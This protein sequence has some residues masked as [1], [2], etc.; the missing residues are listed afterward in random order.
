MADLI[1]I[2]QPEPQAL[3]P[4]DARREV[5]LTVAGRVVRF[6]FTRITGKMWRSYFA[7]IVNKVERVNG[8]RAETFDSEG[9]LLGLYDDAIVNFSGYEIAPEMKNRR[10]AVPYKHRVAAGMALRS[11]AAIGTSQ[12]VLSDTV[13]ISLTAFWSADAAGQ[14]SEFAGLIHR[15]RQPN[16]DQLKRYR[17]GVARTL[18][19]GDAQNGTTVYPLPLSV[20]MSLYDEL[21][22]EVEGYSV[23]GQALTGREAIAQEM[24]GY[25]KA[26]AALQLFKRDDEEVAIGAKQVPDAK[27]ADDAAA[28]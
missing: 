3:L 28:A 16:I 25:H 8:Q 7:A 4:L 18:T 27:A 20:A 23:N 1:E 5:A 9:A 24:D 17:M 14:I 15:F 21:I 26:V 6:E 12:S 13:D 2:H 22:E 19:S 11:V 10:D